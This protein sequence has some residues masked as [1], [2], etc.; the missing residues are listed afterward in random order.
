MALTHW[1]MI[2]SAPGLD[3][4]THRVDW[5][6]D[7]CRTVIVGVERT[8]DAVPVAKALVEDGVQLIELCGAF[9]AEPTARLLEATGHAVPIGPVRYGPEVVAQ[10]AAIF[11]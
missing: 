3:P 9:G 11:A 5:Q 4:A 6:T 7:A 2:V 10:V 8:E 1:A